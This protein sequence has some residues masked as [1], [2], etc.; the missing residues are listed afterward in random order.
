ML[1]LP[2][3][4]L[5]PA[6]LTPEISASVTWLLLVRSLDARQ[7]HSFRPHVL[8]HTLGRP[9]LAPKPVVKGLCCSNVEPVGCNA[10]SAAGI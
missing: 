7:D 1:G 2:L 10:S 4:K 9:R 3:S 6:N 5:P 8:S